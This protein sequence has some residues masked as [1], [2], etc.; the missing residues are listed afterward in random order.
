[1]FNLEEKSLTE[2]KINQKFTDMR[3]RTQDRNAFDFK[4]R[5]S[6]QF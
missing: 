1:M 2:M 6:N 3:A 4:T 5:G